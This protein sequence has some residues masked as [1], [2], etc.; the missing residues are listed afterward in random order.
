M[1]INIETTLSLKEIEMILSSKRCHKYPL[2]HGEY[3]LGINWVKN[4]RKFICLFY[5][6]GTKDKWGYQTTVKSFFYGKVLKVNNKYR[7]IGVSCVNIF[8]IIATL[9]IL[10]LIVFYADSFNFDTIFGIFFCF[11]IFILA[12]LNI[13]KGNRKIKEY[14]ERQFS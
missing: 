10:C 6:D 5:E 1:L 14:L 2:F 3:D 11:L 9:I 4:N 8:F 12:N 13:S 7:I